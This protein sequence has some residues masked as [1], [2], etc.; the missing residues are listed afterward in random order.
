MK[1]L[2]FAL[3]FCASVS[4]QAQHNTVYGCL[5]P[6][7]RG[8]GLGYARTIHNFGIYGDFAQGKSRF[9]TKHW[10]YSIGAIIIP[11]QQN[12]GYKFQF[13]MG[14]SY[15]AYSGKSDSDLF[16]TSKLKTL[17]FEPGCGAVINRKFYAGLSYGV[18]NNFATLKCGL[19]F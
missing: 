9:D 5:T 8:L 17:D 6:D 14:L 4:V 1:K 3:L 18:L 7:T 13:G 11:R 12:T 19:K 15:N 16:D 2:L 10:K